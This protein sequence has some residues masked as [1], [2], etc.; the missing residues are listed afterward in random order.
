LS[1][2]YY[3][4]LFEF[5]YESKEFVRQH[6]SMATWRH[7]SASGCKNNNNKHAYASQTEVCGSSAHGSV[8]AVRL[9]VYD[10]A[11]GS[12]RLSSIAAV[13]GS[14]AAYSSLAV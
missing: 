13:C 7:G 1:L 5:I 12:V 10:C 9:V 14:A 3:L 6:G 11:C 4:N 8:R 2:C